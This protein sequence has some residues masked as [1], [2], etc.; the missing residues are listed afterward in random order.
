MWGDERERVKKEE[1]F[2]L[3]RACGITKAVVEF[4][5]G[6]DEGGPDDIEVTREGANEPSELP[7]YYG[8]RDGS[9]TREEQL[10][11]LLARPVYAE[12]GTFAG[13]FYV[14]GR[15]V[16]DLEARTVRMTGDEDVPQSQSLGEREF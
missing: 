2:N 4:S 3:M 8:S 7:A 14:H 13:E 6:N 16:W 1:T 5:G 12:Y 9:G 15:V 11:D 10:A